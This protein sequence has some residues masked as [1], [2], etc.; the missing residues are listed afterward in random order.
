MFAQNEPMRVKVARA[1]GEKIPYMVV[2]G[3]KEVEQ[4]VVAVRERSE[5][6][7]GMWDPQKLID[8]VAEAH[9][10]VFK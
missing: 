8:M 6:D 10:Y 3:D 7:K 4:G 9:R 2:L 5:G 1:Q